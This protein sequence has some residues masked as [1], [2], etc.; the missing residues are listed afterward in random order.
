MK[1]TTIGS[2]K[3]EPPFRAA[4]NVQ[5]ATI[6]VRSAYSSKQCAP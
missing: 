4:T 1:L 3:A 5:K 2:S 6:H